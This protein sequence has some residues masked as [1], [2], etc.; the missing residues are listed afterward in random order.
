MLAHRI[1]EH[2]AAFDEG[3]GDAV[4]CHLYCDARSLVSGQAAVLMTVWPVK[5]HM[6]E[7]SSLFLSCSDL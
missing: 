2:S 1:G 5:L 7:L 6:A 4:N 3:H